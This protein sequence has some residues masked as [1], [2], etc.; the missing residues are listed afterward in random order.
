[1]SFHLLWSLFRAGQDLEAVHETTGERASHAHR[2][3]TD[4]A[5]LTLNRAAPADRDPTR[6]VGVRTGS[7][8]SG[9]RPVLP[10]LSVGRNLLSQGPHHAKDPRLCRES[11]RARIREKTLLQTTAKLVLIL[12]HIRVRPEPPRGQRAAGVSAVRRAK[13]KSSSSRAALHSCELLANSTDPSYFCFGDSCSSRA[14]YAGQVHAEYEG[15]FFT[16]AFSGVCVLSNTLLLPATKRSFP[17]TK[18]ARIAYTARAC[19]AMGRS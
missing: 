12:N 8:G 15:F 19:S 4:D 3:P 16:R 7:D 17:L 10:L 13:S 6:L 5:P 14:Q 9:P 11:P 18:R 2:D 1:M